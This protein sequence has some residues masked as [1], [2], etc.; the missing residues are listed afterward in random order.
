MCGALCRIAFYIMFSGSVHR[1]CPAAFFPEGRF[2]PGQ[3]A[4]CGRRIGWPSRCIGGIICATFIFIPAA[5]SGYRQ[6]ARAVY[7]GSGG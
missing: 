6:A 3:H 5:A 2:V 1:C 7:A 4:N